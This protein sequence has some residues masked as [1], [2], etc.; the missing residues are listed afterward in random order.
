MTCQISNSLQALRITSESFR[1]EPA[2][3]PLR[4]RNGWMTSVAIGFN[5]CSIKKREASRP[6]GNEAR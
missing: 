1:G 6:G 3:C 4:K 5:G 2:T